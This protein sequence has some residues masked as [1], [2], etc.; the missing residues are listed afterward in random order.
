MYSQPEKIVAITD[1]NSIVVL[2]M[3]MIKFIPDK[4][5]S[6]NFPNELTSIKAIINPNICVTVF[7][8]PHIDAAIT[9]PDFSTAISLYPDTINSLNRTIIGIHAGNFVASTN[10]IIAANTRILS[11]IGS[12]NFPNVVTSFL[13]LAKYPSSL[14]VIEAIIK[15]KSINNHVIGILNISPSILKNGI[16]TII[17]TNIILKI[18]NLFGKFISNSFLLNNFIIST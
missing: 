15:I 10:I 11:A 12:R 8:F 3:F 13:D 6:K 2:A 16:I 7:N 17:G 9:F 14:S 4:L 18:V 5:P 1:I